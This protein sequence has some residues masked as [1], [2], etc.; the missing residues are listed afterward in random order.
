[1]KICFDCKFFRLIN[2][3][4]NAETGKC[5]CEPTEVVVSKTRT[6]CRHFDDKTNYPLSDSNEMLYEREG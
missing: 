4:V 5:S 3:T 2:K 1:M 6:A